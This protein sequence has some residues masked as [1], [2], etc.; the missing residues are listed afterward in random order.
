MNK[1]LEAIVEETSPISYFDIILDAPIG[2][3]IMADTHIIYVNGYLS[4]MV[5]LTRGEMLGHRFCAYFKED[6]KVHDYLE[7]KT[8]QIHAHIKKKDISFTP[9]IIQKKVCE[10]KGP[11]KESYGICCF[12]SDDTVNAKMIKELEK[13]NRRLKSLLDDTDAAV[14]SFAP[15][16]MRD[17]LIA[18]NFVEGL[19][20]CSRKD[21]T[22]RRK[23]IF[24]YVH[25]GDKKAVMDFYLLFPNHVDSAEI[26]YRIINELGEIR[27]VHDTGHTLYKEFG[28]GMPRRIDHTI[29]DITERK[30]NELQLIEK[31]RK[32]KNIIKNSH[33]IIYRV[34]LDGDFLSLNP[35]GRKTLGDIENIKSCYKD[36]NARRALVQEI[37]EKGV[38]KIRTKWITYEGEEIDVIVNAVAEYGIDDTIISYQGIVH[39]ITKE[40]AM[41]KLEATKK[42][43]GGLSDAIASP[44]MTISMGIEMLQEI[45][46]EYDDESLNNIHQILAENYKK[47]ETALKKTRDT[48]WQ[49]VEI[50]DGSGTGSKIYE[51]KE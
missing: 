35:S 43:C 18:N 23:H 50:S 39:N 40:L 8:S 31:Q 17:V 36:E 3:V 32:L 37:L 29:T 33:D 12:I 24:D 21:L 48:Y 42:T 28:Y 45:G 30:Q 46:E 44:L 41:S 47:V 2:V 25:P 26:E 10:L 15:Y 27:W 14:I 19:F 13:E 9:V 5:G 38:S 16:D 4:G 6:M 49:I 1:E 22:K 7:D 20:G 51:F 34:N 11:Y